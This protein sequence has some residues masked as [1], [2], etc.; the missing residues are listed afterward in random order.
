M[1]EH[2]CKIINN[3]WDKLGDILSSLEGV[4]YLLFIWISALTA[5]I[6]GLYNEVIITTF[7][8]IFV[9]LV[10]GVARSI[11]VGNYAT[12]FLLKNTILKIG[13]YFSI[14][15]VLIGIEHL[16]CIESGVFV[17]SFTVI[18]AATELISILGNIAIVKP[19]LIC[20]KLV[21]RMVI[22]EVA[23]KLKI[24][25]KEAQ[26]YFAGKQKT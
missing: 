26:K 14:M 15:F 2:L 20:V 12:S 8:C 23:R 5:M 13:A 22:G 4:V 6:F 3:L 11:K 25:D 18:I 10:W 7:F 9:D 21:R 16:L 1:E 24:S 19:S 17:I